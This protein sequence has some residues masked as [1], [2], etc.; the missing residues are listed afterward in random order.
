LTST[1]TD[2][3]RHYNDKN[4]LLYV[5]ISLSALY[6][7]LQHRKSS[8]WYNAIR[9]ITIEHFKDRQAA[10]DAEKQAIILEKPK[11][12]IAGQPRRHGIAAGALAALIAEWEQGRS[13]QAE[14][15][16]IKP[17]IKTAQPR[18]ETAPALPRQRAKPGPKPI[19]GRALSSTERSQR[20]RA[21]LRENG[22]PQ[23]D[24][25]TANSAAQCAS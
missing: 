13:K 14:R 17:H 25:M 23:L 19:L 10:E 7:L 11:Y 2:L 20:R 22:I 4:E 12:N 3:Y 15:I 9:T 24:R 5:G 21:R 6:R 8:S 1:P 18:T 16:C